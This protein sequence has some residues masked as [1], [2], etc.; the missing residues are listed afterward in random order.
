MPLLQPY[1]FAFV[2]LI[3]K[4]MHYFCETREATVIIDIKRFKKLFDF[5]IDNLFTL[6]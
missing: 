2:I 6:T 5:F 3:E 1:K 4:S